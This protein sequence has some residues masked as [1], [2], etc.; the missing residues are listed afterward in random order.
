MV[1]YVVLLEA[2][3]YKKIGK[4]DTGPNMEEWGC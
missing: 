2:K 4:K 1:N 3:D